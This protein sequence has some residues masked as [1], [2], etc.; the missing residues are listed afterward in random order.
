MNV[1]MT[2]EDLLAENQPHSLN[3]SDDI[4]IVVGH[5]TDLL[6]WTNLFLYQT[7]TDLFVADHPVGVE[8]RVQDVIQLLNNQHSKDSLLIG[9]CG[10][11]GVGKTTLAK[12]VYNRIRHDFEVAKCFL[13]NV[14]VVCEQDN[15]NVSL[16]QRL[17]QKKTFLVFDDV[18]RVDQFNALCG[19]FKWFGQGSKIIITT[20][21]RQ[22][23]CNL[24]VDYVYQ[25]K[26]MDD[27][28]SL[29]LFSWHAFKQPSPI[30]GFAELSIDI[31]KY[32]E[33]IPLF[34]QL[35]GSFLLARTS[36]TEWESVLGKLGSAAGSDFAK[37]KINFEGLSDNCMKVFLDIFHFCI[38]MDQEDATKILEEWRH[39]VDTGINVLVQQSLVTVDWM[40]KIRMH[41]L[42]ELK[43]REIMWELT[44][45]VSNVR[46]GFLSGST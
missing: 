34:L 28:E 42:I 9:I 21:D 20:R 13:L 26:E 32:C 29:E 33:G 40:N 14:G 7:K 46:Y 39:R 45:G 1:S 43:G 27:D 36:K 31:V 44:K 10:V 19:S 22:I 11:A 17:H 24:Q 3:E 25:I 23:L 18:N 37:L 8:S 41:D 35:I 4:R 30:H 6:D 15:G 38:G 2:V 12:A 16:Q 5:V